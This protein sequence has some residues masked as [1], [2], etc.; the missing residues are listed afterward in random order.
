MKVQARLLLCFFR[1]Q[2]IALNET[3]LKRI[4]KQ[5]GISNYITDLHYK[6]KNIL[7][8]KWSQINSNV[9]I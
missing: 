5:D 4:I 3:N 2:V 6:Y 8:V 9:L 1:L 7:R